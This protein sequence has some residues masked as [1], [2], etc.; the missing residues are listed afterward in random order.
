[1]YVNHD[2][3]YAQT[4]ALWY[5]ITHDLPKTRVS[6]LASGAKPP[7]GALQFGRFSTCVA[8]CR[9]IGEADTYWLARV[10]D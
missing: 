6:I 4:Q 5:A 8:S 2:D 3:V 7:G 10:R 1:V 9:Q